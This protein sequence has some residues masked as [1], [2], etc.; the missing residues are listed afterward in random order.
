MKMYY[1]ASSTRIA[2]R[3]GTADLLWLVGDHDRAEHD[4]GSTSQVANYD[5]TA[6]TNGRQLYR[7][8]G[9]KRYPS[10][11]NGLPTTFRYTGQ[12]QDSSLGGS[13]GLFYYEARWYDSYPIDDRTHLNSSGPL[14]GHRKKQ[15]TPRI[16]YSKCVNQKRPPPPFRGRGKTRKQG[17]CSAVAPQQPCFLNRRSEAVLGGMGETVW[18]RMSYL[19]IL[20]SG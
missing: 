12:R 3:T 4:S 16:S 7:P 10:G 14:W 1:Y 9:E 8:W 15:A 18:P 6:Y 19:E 13:D 20:N 17:C 2:M 11:A 5:C